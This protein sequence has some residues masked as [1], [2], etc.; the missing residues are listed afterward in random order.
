MKYVVVVLKVLIVNFVFSFHSNVTW[1]KLVHWSLF[2]EV[3]MLV[4]QLVTQ[5]AGSDWNM[6]GTIWKKSR[7][8][9]I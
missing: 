6:K 8:F 3:A 9:F 7:V 5:L 1:L 2:V 4:S